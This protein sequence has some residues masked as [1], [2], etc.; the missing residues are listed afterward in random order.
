MGL[1]PALH[2]QPIL[3]M[4][5]EAATIET[6]SGGRL[7]HYRHLTAPAGDVVLIWGWK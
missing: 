7:Q 6:P 2:G 3:A 5:D 1:V 4:T